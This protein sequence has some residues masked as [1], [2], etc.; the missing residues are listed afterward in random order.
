MHPGEVVHTVLRRLTHTGTGGYEHKSE[1][2]D[3]PG[4]VLHAI[5]IKLLG[6]WLFLIP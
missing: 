6:S 1:Q 4:L 3:D 2:A 5:I